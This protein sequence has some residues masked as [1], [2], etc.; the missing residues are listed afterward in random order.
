M[1]SLALAIAIAALT[2]GT[3][4]CAPERADCSITPQD[5]QSNLSLS[6]AEFD[7]D[8][9]TATTAR[10]LGDRKCDAAAA[11]ATEH[12]LA[13]RPDLSA[14]EINILTWH[15]AQYLAAAGDERTAAKVMLAA[16]RPPANPPE[17]DGFEWNTYVVGSWAFLIKDRQALEAATSRLSAAPG[18][19]NGMNAKV[20]RRF[21]KCFDR[22]Y[23]EA[24]DSVSCEPGS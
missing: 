22:S 9:V 8:G 11:Q 14:S 23:I 10:A 13:Y 3:A 24:Y 19:R 6:F 4:W 16:R 7:Q 1:K 21:S 2:C 12:Y 20:L 17:S 18:V 15:L 5:L